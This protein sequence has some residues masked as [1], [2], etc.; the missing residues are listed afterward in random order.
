MASLQCFLGYPE[1]DAGVPFAFWIT[2]ENDAL[3]IAGVMN[4]GLAGVVDLES[5]RVPMLNPDAIIAHMTTNGLQ[6]V[7]TAN[8]VWWV[9]SQLRQGSLQQF[10]E[11]E[12]VKLLAVS[13]VEPSHR[14]LNNGVYNPALANQTSEMVH[15]E[16]GVFFPLPESVLGE[17]VKGVALAVRNDTAIQQDILDAVVESCADMAFD[18][19]YIPTVRQHWH[20]AL[21]ALALV[22]DA[23]DKVVTRDV[24]EHNRRAVALGA[25]GS[26][27]PFVRVWTHQQLVNSVA[28]AQLMARD[29]G[30][31]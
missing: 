13:G 25:P 11:W 16:T 15:P 1:P 14:L 7:D 24:V 22:Y 21:D 5:E 28:I 6:L 29:E 12:V 2:L 20:T 10:D 23:Q 30:Q 26:Q 27:V 31:S 19:E 18:D 9:E 4:R 17:G 3:L 8:C